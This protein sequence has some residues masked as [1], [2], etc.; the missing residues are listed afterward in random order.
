MLVFGGSCRDLHQVTGDEENMDRYFS[1]VLHRRVVRICEILPQENRVDIHETKWTVMKDNAHL[2]SSWLDL[3][4]NEESCIDDTEESRQAGLQA[5]DELQLYFNG[6]IL[7][8]LQT[9]RNSDSNLSSIFHSN[10]HH[11]DNNVFRLHRG[12]L[13]SD[14]LDCCKIICGRSI[15]INDE[16]NIL[17]NIRLLIEGSDA[18]SMRAPRALMAV[19]NE[20]LGAILSS[21]MTEAQSGVI[22]LQTS[23]GKYCSISFLLY[24]VADVLAVMPEDLTEL[25]VLGNQY[26]VSGLLLHC[27]YVLCRQVDISNAMV[28]LAYADRYDMSTLK[29]CCVFL[30][31]KYF[32]EFAPFFRIGYN[33]HEESAAFCAAN[34]DTLETES[35][36]IVT[37]ELQNYIQ[38]QRRNPACLFYKGIF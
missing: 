21:K 29:E 17:S 5:N 19:R 28:L 32:N 4:A 23:E 26:G 25:L 31:L 6:A 34:I 18:I 37:M 2:M 8:K 22:T 15:P 13:S 9:D 14:L 7:K 33:G 35:T 1:P 20:F 38:N 24:L 27:E 10:F 12:T 30:I 3:I 11:L 36:P 16:D